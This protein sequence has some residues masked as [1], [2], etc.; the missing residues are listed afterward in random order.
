MFIK[1][2]ICF[3]L[4]LG[5]QT[6]VPAQDAD[7]VIFN[8][9]I[10][11]M[12]VRHANPSA[13]A[14]RQG[15]ILALGTDDAMR[16][17]AGPKTRLVDAQT[18]FIMPGLIE[19]HAHLAGLG[20]SLRN[21][22]LRGVK[23]Y[24]EVVARVRS[25]ANERTKGAWIIGRGWDQNLWPGQEFPD[26]A[27]L[28]AAVP[29]HPVIL[30]RVD[31]HALLANDR[32]MQIAGIDRETR[33]PEGGEI[34]R[35]KDGEPTGV[36]VD[37]AEDLIMARAPAIDTA[38][39]EAA[40]LLAESSCFA[41]GITTFHD[42]GMAP[43]TSLMVTKLMAAGRFKMRVYAMA[44]V[45]DLETATMLAKEPPLVGAFDHRFTLRAWKIYADGALG[46]RGAALLD[47]YADRSGHRGL[48]ITR[49]E[50]LAAISAVAL[51]HGYQACV[52]AIGDRAN[53]MIL[54][55]W[56]E[57]F[58]SHP[59]RLDPRFRIEHAQVIHEDDIPRFARL[60]VIASMQ[61][62]HCTSDMAWVPRRL[63]AKRAELGA[64]AWRTLLDSGAT[65][66]N[67]S[68]APVESI[69]PFAGLYAA[70][71]RQDREGKPPGGFFPAQRMSRMEALAS[72]TLA[73]AYAAFEE[74]LKGRL[75]PG[76]LADFILI[77]RDLRSCEDAALLD[78]EVLA[79]IL[80]GEIVY[81]RPR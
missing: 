59:E 24:E 13:L 21:L 57:L 40:L 69:S 58:A 51:E 9:R 3:L 66:C 63:A 12:D 8:A 11:T 73:G 46:S 49:A 41:Q 27:A 53:R 71:T 44:S 62:R 79:T 45:A 47:D 30:T 67:G 28:S 72:Y 35:R 31:G 37:R 19:S 54:D 81:R 50:A 22:D 1:A 77:D 10:E 39:L 43:G 14:V 34:L 65:I 5:L 15:R 25:T 33:A 38:D 64:Y 18:A 20:S 75:A 32:A 2:R 70:V 52:H 26:H 78:A 6:P 29:D 36:F 48:L 16:A 42:A 56:T 4:L 74:N 55:V 7:L 17:L 80:G 61:T 68:D 60:G 76:L 23:S